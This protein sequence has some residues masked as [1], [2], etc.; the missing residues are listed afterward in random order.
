MTQ[1][2]TRLA[3]RVLILDHSPSESEMLRQALDDPAIVVLASVATAEQ[4]VQACG[5]SLPDVILVNHHVVGPDAKAAISHIMH[6]RPL[7]IVVISAVASPEDGTH[8]FR[9]Q[10]AGAL[11]VVPKPRR[12]DQADRAHLVQTLKLMAEVKVVRRWRNP[13]AELPAPAAR[14]LTAMPTMGKP[15]IEVVA[16]GASTGGPVVLKRIL[17]RLPSGFPVPILI[18]QHITTG[19]IDGLARWLSLDSPIPVQMAVTGEVLRPGRAYLA[20]D[21]VHLRVAANGTLALDRDAAVNGHRPAVSC[22][23]RSVAERCGASAVGIL[24][25]GMGKDGAAELKLMRDAGAITIAQDEASSVVYGMPGEAIRRE[26]ATHV[27][28][29]DEIAAALPALVAGPRRSEQ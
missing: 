17:S 22:L 29:P 18:V 19:F 16:I 1:R 24:L 5:Q 3:V 15:P 6:A 8:A 4:A 23:F 11:A 27:M 12:L 2:R 10:E 28:S 13:Y 7:P 20:P 26:A 9:L 25:T 21:E 14:G